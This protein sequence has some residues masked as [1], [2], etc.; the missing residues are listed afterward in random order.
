MYSLLA[1]LSVEFFLL[2]YG[3]KK[4]SFN[5][6]SPKV[7]QSPSR[8]TMLTMGAPLTRTIEF[9]IRLIVIHPWGEQNM[10]ACSGLT[11]LLRI[12]TLLLI[13]EP[14]WSFSPGR[15]QPTSRSPFSSRRMRTAMG[16]FVSGSV[17]GGEVACSSRS[18]F[19][20][21]RCWM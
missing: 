10:E 15:S 2:L 16:F 13:E 20:F 17:G 11:P 3:L 18:L 12:L 8:T 6:A 1:N 21:S 7:I 14:I 19:W 4:W 9:W 5:S